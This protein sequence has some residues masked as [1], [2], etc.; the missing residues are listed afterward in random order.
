[1]ANTR[2]KIHSYFAGL[3]FSMSRPRPSPIM[4]IQVDNHNEIK[5]NA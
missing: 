2:D 5:D 3:Y 1:M 4:N